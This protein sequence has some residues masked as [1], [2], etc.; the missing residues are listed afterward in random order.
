M[1]I[2]SGRI[3]HDPGAPAGLLQHSTSRDSSSWSLSRRKENNCQHNQERKGKGLKSL[4]GNGESHRVVLFEGLASITAAR[5][6]T[7]GKRLRFL[8]TPVTK[9]PRAKV[10]NATIFFMSILIIGPVKENN[11]FT[12]LGCVVMTRRLWRTSN[13]AH[14]WRQLADWLSPWFFFHEMASRLG[15]LLEFLRILRSSAKDHIKRF[16]RS[17][18]ALLLAYLGRRLSK[19]WCSWFSKSGAHGNTK[20]T[21]P[22]FPRGRGGSCSV[23]CSSSARR[24]YA[25]RVAASTVPASANAANRPSRDGAEWQPETL[26][27]SPISATLP[28]DPPWGPSPD[29]GERSPTNRSSGNL[30]I[31]STGASDRPSAI[32]ISRSSSR[33]S[34]QSDRSSR[35]PRATHRQFGPGS[36]ASWPR[37]KGRSSRST[38]RGRSSRSHSPQPS[39][40]SPQT[41]TPSPSSHAGEQLSPP[42]THRGRQRT[43]SIGLNVQSPSTDSLLRT[44]SINTQEHTEALMTGEASTG[45]RSD[46][47]QADGLDAASHHSHTASS[48]QSNHFTLPEGR[49]LLPINSDQIPRYTK[50][51][52]TQVDCFFIAT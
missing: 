30:S 33:A 27:L 40:T 36:G 44:S 14:W 28:A 41:F 42:A 17:C 52:A 4:K 11:D 39:I 16:P 22:S 9:I 3:R 31:Q 7:N 34:V 12:N 26:P 29:L 1:A 32:P 37:S 45:L 38:S 23:L 48:A 24:G 2:G 35:H 8:V 46:I 6:L 47:F 51:I 43:T 10:T 49:S 20:P 18:W 21:Y 5:W 50:N 25:G 19:W 13:G 15:A